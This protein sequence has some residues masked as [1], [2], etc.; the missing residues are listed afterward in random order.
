MKAATPTPTTRQ[1]FSQSSTI[2]GYYNTSSSFNFTWSMNTQMLPGAMPTILLR[3]GLRTRDLRWELL[4]NMITIGNTFLMELDFAVHPH[5]P[6]TRCSRSIWFHTMLSVEP[7]MQSL[8]RKP[9]ASLSMGGG[10]IGDNKESNFAGGGGSKIKDHDLQKIFDSY[11]AGIFIGISFEMQNGL[12]YRMHQWSFSQGVSNIH[13]TLTNHGVPDSFQFSTAKDP[14]NYG[15]P[16]D[17]VPDSILLASGTNPPNDDTDK[18]DNS[19]PFHCDIMPSSSNEDES[20][21]IKYL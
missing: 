2:S 3:N 10:N 11:S 19:D 20:A 8:P 21:S 1:H 9:I 13:P 4:T 18:S 12:P 7:G 16:E 6:L 14:N 15:V 5:P 17:G